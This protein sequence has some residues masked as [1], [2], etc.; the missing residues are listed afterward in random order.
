M[1]IEIN[2]KKIN[3]IKCKS[4]KDKLLGL[5][6]KKDKINNTYLF[7]KCNSIHTFFMKQNIDVCMIDKNNKIVFLKENVSK[8]KILYSKKGHFTLEMPLNTC[9]YLKINDYIKLKE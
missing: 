5:C 9:K 4:F 6:F 2:N 3:I 8:N 1:Y 7:Y